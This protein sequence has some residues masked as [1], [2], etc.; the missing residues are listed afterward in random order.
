MADRRPDPVPAAP[1]AKHPRGPGDAAAPERDP[2]A[3]DALM[4]TLDAWAGDDAPPV[5]TREAVSRNDPFRVLVATILSLRT[6][7][8]VTEAASARLFALA[9]TPDALAALD[10]ATIA[11]AIRPANFYPT[12]A[13]R[14]RD[15][16]IRL[17]DEFGGRVPPDLDV[18]LTFQGVGRKT[19]NLVLTE[20][21]DLP[22][23]CVDTHVHRILSRLGMLAT[24]DPLETEMA[25]RAVLPA[26][27]WKPINTRLVAFGQKMCRPQSPWCSRCPLADR[28]RRVGVGRTR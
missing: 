23:V 15:I 27:H 26:A 25:L 10:P 17:R 9:D 8:D 16:A 2:A 4:A 12:K 24:R 11:A 22:G 13:V 6:T 7:D 1:A 18:L 21:F 3:W 19:A 28:C 20:G 14:L 5:V